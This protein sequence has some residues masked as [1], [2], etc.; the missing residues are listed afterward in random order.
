MSF[1]CQRSFCECVVQR[2]PP[3]KLSQQSNLAVHVHVHYITN[4][5]IEFKGEYLNMW[6]DPMETLFL[7]NEVNRIWRKSKINFVVTSSNEIIHESPSALNEI[8]NSSRDDKTETNWLFL[9][10][11]KSYRPNAINIYL[12]PWIGST[13]QGFR[14]NKRSYPHPLTQTESTIF[15]SVWSNKHLGKESPPEHIPITEPEPFVRGSLGRTM[16][17]EI[18]HV[19]GLNHPSQS[20]ISRLMGGPIDGYNLTDSEIQTARAFA[21]SLFT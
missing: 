18:G 9:N 7:S 6:M 12:F 8:A 20:D 5:N 21:K 1:P 15:M 3:I 10:L 2:P 16:A 17:H 11:V 4:A 14:P 19:L 13:R